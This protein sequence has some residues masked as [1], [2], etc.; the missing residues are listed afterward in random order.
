MK[1]E[2]SKLEQLVDALS[3]FAEYSETPSA[4]PSK[5]IL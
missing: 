2:H 5:N 1:T 4:P 3:V